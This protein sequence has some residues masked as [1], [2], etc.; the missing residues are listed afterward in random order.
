MQKVIIVVIVLLIVGVGGFFLIGSSS[1]GESCTAD[2]AIVFESVGSVATS[3]AG[4]SD[5]VIVIFNNGEV[6]PSCVKVSQG[7]E[8]KWLNAGDEN[9]QIGAD[10]HP[11]HTGNKEV[12]YGGFVLDMAPGEEKTF[13]IS[14]VG[15]TG[16]HDHLNSS[17]GGA[18]IVD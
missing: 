3:S 2:T 17:T 1:P 13:T 18:I 4:I 15:K 12:S 9:I 7:E 10:P 16:Y 6:T 8:I 14:K 5:P 11:V